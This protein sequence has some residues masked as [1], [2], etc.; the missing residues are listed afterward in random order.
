M[1]KSVNLIILILG[2]SFC[3]DAIG[4]QTATDRAISNYQALASR[5][6]SSADYDKLGAAYLQKGRET[7]DFS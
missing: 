7:A 6:S 5:S 2:V 3:A 1:A 4:Q